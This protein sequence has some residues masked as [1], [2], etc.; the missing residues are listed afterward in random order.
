MYYDPSGH[1]ALFTFLHATIS[2]LFAT[3]VAALSTIAILYVLKSD[4]KNPK[5]TEEEIPKGI[6]G[7]EYYSHELS[8]GKIVQFSYDSI[9]NDA[10]TLLTVYNSFKLSRQEIDEFLN[11]LKYSDE[12]PCSSINIDRA[13]NEIMWHNIGHAFGIDYEA[14][15]TTQVFFDSD[16]IG[17][18]PLSWIINHLRWW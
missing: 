16:D 5:A 7:K 17:H 13:R 12:H 15:R 14:T 8:S 3:A 2:T 9:N 1:F 18:G 11:W 10:E 4:S 6:E